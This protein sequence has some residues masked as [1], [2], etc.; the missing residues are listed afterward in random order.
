[1]Y[2]S[3]YHEIPVVSYVENTY[4]EFVYSYSSSNQSE[5]ADIGD[6]AGNAVPANES[7]SETLDQKINFYTMVRVP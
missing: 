6:A 7:S 4:M 3:L 1:M 5:T 2:V